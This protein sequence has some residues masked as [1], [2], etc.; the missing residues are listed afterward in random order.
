[1]RTSTKKLHIAIKYNIPL[2]LRLQKTLKAAVK[3]RDYASVKRLLKNGANPNEQDIEGST[4]LHFAAKDN[5]IFIA[6]LLIQNRADIMI[7]DNAGYTA[8]DY[9]VDK[10]FTS[11]Q[12]LF[13]ENLKR[14][15]S[16]HNTSRLFKNFPFEIDKSTENISNQF[17]SYASSQT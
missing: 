17:I 13:E 10:Q 16:T 7:K 11:L 14:T 9:A 8:L 15:K 4:A 6:S 3:K 5:R 1:M 2:D 12:R